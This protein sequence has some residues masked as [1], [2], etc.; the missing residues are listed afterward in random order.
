MFHR[1]L[2]AVALALLAGAAIPAADA[3]LTVKVGKADPPKELSDAVRKP[4][5]GEALSVSDEAGKL[6]CTVW[7]AKALDTKATA[8][9]AKA[10]LKYS[11][12]EETTLVA[13]VKFESEWK[14]YRK[15][16]VK[17]G[18]YTLRLATQLMDGDHMGTAPY[19]EFLLLCPA[20]ADKAPEA[21]EVKEL[22]ELS[23][24]S[25]GR[26]HPTVML[27][28]PNKA[29]ADSTA[30]QAKPKEHIVLSY[31]VPATAAG[32]KA[33]LGFSLVIVGATSAE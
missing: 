9:Q 19:N 1:A 30:I 29:P 24:K 10:G 3:K 31:R 5:S 12:V 23:A 26:K 6:V 8:D 4:L 27:L 13:A 33:A 15:Q 20:D 28:F 2:A 14:D 17:P 22:Y 16:K 32:Q 7:P 11:Q 25:A 21:M 18:V